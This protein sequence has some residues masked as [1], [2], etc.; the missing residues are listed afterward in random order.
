MGEK[1]PLLKKAGTK[2]LWVA[3]W[4]EWDSRAFSGSSSNSRGGI[5]PAPRI[6]ENLQGSGGMGVGGFCSLSISNPCSSHYMIGGH[7][8]EKKTMFFTKDRISGTSKLE[9]AIA[10]DSAENRVSRKSCSDYRLAPSSSTWAVIVT[11]ATVSPDPT[12]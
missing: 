6:V 10:S 1:R 4:E 5:I 7:V 2:W 11:T 3:F 8:D 12:P 9:G